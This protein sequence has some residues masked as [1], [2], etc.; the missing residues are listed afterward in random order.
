MSERDRF[1]NEDQDFGSDDV[2]AHSKLP[3]GK[4]A[5]MEPGGDDDDS[6]EAHSK[7]PPGKG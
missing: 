1:E 2:E 6:V 7:L 4:G 3:P 5:A